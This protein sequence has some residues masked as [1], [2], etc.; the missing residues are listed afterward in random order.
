MTEPD[1]FEVMNQIIVERH[2]PIALDIA[3]ELET[4][5][6]RSP[7]ELLADWLDRP[8]TAISRVR[9]HHRRM[10]R[11]HSQAARALDEALAAVPDK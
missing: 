7:L 6:S 2:Q 11:L 4:F 10:I 5:N 1:P 3:E 9:E 8:E